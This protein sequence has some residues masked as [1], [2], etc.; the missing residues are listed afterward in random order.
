MG[1]VSTTPK[2]ILKKFMT[3]I[4]YTKTAIKLSNLISQ[5]FLK[6]GE[7]SNKYIKI[8]EEMRVT[9]KPIFRHLVLYDCFLAGLYK[10]KAWFY[11]K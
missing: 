2:M 10:S 3:L 4:K 9:T 6:L 1:W 11:H 8:W 7:E 5:F